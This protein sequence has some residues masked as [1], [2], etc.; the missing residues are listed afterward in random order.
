MMEYGEMSVMTTLGQ[1]R[2]MLPAAASITQEEL[3]AMQ[4]DLFHPVQVCSLANDS[5][6]NSIA[7]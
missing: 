6:S 1:R 4:T 3:S 2:H 5:H 7:Q